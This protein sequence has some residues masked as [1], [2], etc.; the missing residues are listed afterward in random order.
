MERARLPV[1]VYSVNICTTLRATLQ[2]IYKKVTLKVLR[3]FFRVVVSFRLDSQSRIA[4]G[5]VT[6]HPPPNPIRYASRV[7]I[8][9]GAR[10]F[11]CSSSVEPFPRC[12]VRHSYN[13]RFRNL[14]ASRSRASIR[15]YN[16]VVLRRSVSTFAA[17]R[18][19]GGF[20]VT[21]DAASLFVSH[22]GAQV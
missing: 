7:C 14:A 3:V 10:L 21:T 9:N 11:T 12:A 8:V 16:R 17:S 13:V 6:Y 1:V 19:R 5:T 4:F 18:V 20:S 22:L 15:L 2:G